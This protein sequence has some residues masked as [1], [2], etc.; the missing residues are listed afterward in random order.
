MIKP[1]V[2]TREHLLFIGDSLILNP[3]D[4]T[5]IGWTGR[6]N[7]MATKKNP[8]IQ[9][10]NLGIL[11]ETSEQLHSR[12]E[13]EW[14]LR[15][16]EDDHCFVVI[17]TGMY[18]TYARAGKAAVPLTQTIENLTAM[19]EFL[20]PKAKCLLLGPTPVLDPETNQRIKRLNTNMQEFCK[21]KHIHFVNL[22]LLL[23]NDVAFKRKL[24]QFPK[25]VDF[26]PFYEKIASHIGDDSGWWFKK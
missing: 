3:Y 19:F 24:A 21:K 14:N 1:P 6:L 8:D 16:F 12:L 18:D 20:K 10:H 5:T 17:H 26:A 9:Y 15:F 23:Q 4:P 22:F 11:N 25:Q 13:M 7:M 2:R